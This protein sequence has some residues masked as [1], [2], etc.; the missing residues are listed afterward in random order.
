MTKN[1]NQ[2]NIENM[3]TRMTEIESKLGSKTVCT[4]KW[5]QSTI[6][7]MNGFTHSC[8]HPSTHK[9]P[10]S[11]IKRSP[12]ALHNTEYKKQ[13]R[14]KMLNG[15]QPD[16]CR[17]CWNIENL[18][19]GNISDRTYKSANVEWSYSFLD[20]VID[21]QDTGD[22]DPTYLEVAFDNTCNFKCMYCTPD[23]S[24]KWMEEI[25]QHGPYSVGVGNI[26]WL[27]LSGKMPIPQREYNPY[28]DAFHEWFPKVKEN[29]T[30]FRITGGEPLLSK[31][32]WRTLDE[33]LK[34]PNPNLT[35]GINSNMDVP[36]NL[37]DKLIQYIHELK[38]N[39]KQV[40][41]YTSCEAHG[42]Q[43]EYIR[44]GM[45]Y[46][47]FME[48][49]NK[50]LTQTDTRVNFMVT[51]NA[52]SITSFTKFLSDMYDLRVKYNEN[53]SINRIPLMISYLR[54]PQFQ[55]VRVLP[56]EIKQ[57]Y[58][59]EIITFM[60]QRDR[61]N[62]SNRAG[63]FYLEEIDQAERLKNFMYTDPD[64]I[65]TLREQFRSFY[66]EYDSRKNTN[67]IKTFPELKDFYLGL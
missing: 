60:K 45:K 19:T 18:G 67:F 63:R 29:L 42:E 40:E 39:V 56:N 43:A 66:K 31:N 26:E 49:V 10:I 6:Y 5:L 27:Q 53:D 58:I 34:E 13:V 32:M 2:M 8:H 20:R 35:L 41:I 50:I 59:D 7:L 37:I 36:D 23:I 22:V 15:E 65:D 47:R 21:T 57:R 11:E 44:Y 51:F 17:Y 24:S 30:N 38:K 61:N 4:A 25:E 3:L 9:I 48:N 33:L 64:N 52:L 16:E 28:V 55:D 46:E 12:S 54:W 1:L 14:G 62:S